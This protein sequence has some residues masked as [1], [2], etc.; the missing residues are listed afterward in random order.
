MEHNEN[1]GSRWE[2][3]RIE[4]YNQ[5]VHNNKTIIYLLYIMIPGYDLCFLACTTV[6]NYV[7]LIYTR[8][9]VTG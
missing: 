6:Q 5:A 4:K 2:T 1:D 9:I 3:H 7:V 8:S